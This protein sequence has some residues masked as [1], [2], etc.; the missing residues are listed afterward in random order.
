MSGMTVICEN[1]GAVCNSE[2]G[3]CN[4]CWKKL[5]ADNAGED[6]ILEGIGES[7]WKAFIEKNTDYYMPIF[8]KH[9]G[10]TFFVSMNWAAFFMSYDWMFYRR[11]YKAAAV[12][13]LLTTLLMPIMMLLFA[14]P[15]S[16]DIQSFQE[17]ITAYNEYVD[18]GG[19]DVMYTEN[20]KA[21]TP[22]I[23][24]QAEEARSELNGIAVAITWRTVL[25]T[26]VIQPL[27][28]GLFGNAVYKA[29]IKKHI[30][31]PN[32]GGASIAS[33][34]VGVIGVNVI[35]SVLGYLLAGL[36]MMIGV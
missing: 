15:Y 19:E 28:M 6:H 32:G 21:Y 13:Y 14:T 2:D 25:A 8:K 10:K 18:A 7:D 16:N 26:I 30:H 20:G 23:V 29:Y 3:Y 34:I 1:C 27:L 24:E 17:S 31:D 5:T 11:M 12:F 36:I 33:Y 4:T 35:E 22:D 9:E